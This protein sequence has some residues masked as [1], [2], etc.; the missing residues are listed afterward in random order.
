[1]RLF[2]LNNLSASALEAAFFQCCSAHR[3]VKKMRDALPFDSVDSVLAS[4]VVIWRSLGEKDYLE[5]FDGHP[6]IGDPASLKKKYQTT[7]KMASHEQSSVE[8]AGDEVIE[9][10]VDY[11]KA[12]EAKFGY[13]FIVCATGKSAIEMLDILKIRMENDP[14][15][16]I[17]IAAYEQEKITHIRLKNLL[18]DAL[19]STNI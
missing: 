2:E 3:W 18:V 10:L 13:I 12:Y 19:S 9:E 15:E 1:M 4:N 5:A 17:I 7:L 16:E 14:Q 11:N 8:H 6:K